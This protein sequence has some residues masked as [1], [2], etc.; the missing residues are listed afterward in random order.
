MNPALCVLALLAVPRQDPLD[1]LSAAEITAARQILEHSGRLTATMRF[2]TLALREPP[3]DAVL[4]QRGSLAI[5][6]T[7][8]AILFDWATS[9]PVRAHMDLRRA[10]VI[11][12]DTLPS[13]EPPMRIMIR[14]R[15]EEI[16]RGDPR[17]ILALGRRGITDPSLVSLIPALRESRPLPTENGHRVVQAQ[18]FHQEGLPAASTIHGIRL[19]VDLTA[20]VILELSETGSSAIRIDSARPGVSA[21][22]G[23]S[24][25][26]FAGWRVTGP[27]RCSTGPRSPR[28]WPRT[29]IPATRSGI[30]ET[31]AMTDW[32]TR[33]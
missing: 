29:A 16:V 17:W 19:R 11:R 20:G 23:S 28:R 9:T 12:W 7:A 32:E 14:R 25:G 4:T 5:G 6:R 22:E 10:R 31:P 30:R 26:M 15:L 8:E 3:K 13:R 2:A 27:G 21:G 33:S 18:G 1:P 24:S